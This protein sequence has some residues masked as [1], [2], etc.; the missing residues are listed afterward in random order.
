MPKTQLVRLSMSLDE[1]LGHALD[2]L[3]RA[4][5]YQNRSEYVRDMIRERIV[6]QEWEQNAA[7]VLGTITLLYNHHQRELCGRLTEI[8][9]DAQVHILAAT[10]V[11]LSHEICAEMIMVSGSAAEIRKL[12]LA[13]KQPRGIL[14]AALSMS[15]TGEELH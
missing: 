14:H 8:Q 15:S 11:H 1:E 5:N 2:G 10:H 6:D 3:V 7:S 9:H 4:A 13:L 12:Y